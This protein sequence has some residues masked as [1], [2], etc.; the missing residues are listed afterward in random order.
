MHGNEAGGD[1]FLLFMFSSPALINLFITILISNGD[2]KLNLVYISNRFGYLRLISIP[3]VNRFFN[4]KKKSFFQPQRQYC[5]AL[6]NIMFT[7]T[8]YWPNNLIAPLNNWILI[9][10]FPN[11]ILISLYFFRYLG[12]KS[13]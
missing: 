9:S 10:Y 13:C 12:Y 7:L 11:W 1:E 2:K 8:F 5:N 3:I 4:K 6:S